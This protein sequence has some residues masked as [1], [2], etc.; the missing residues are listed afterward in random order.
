MLAKALLPKSNCIFHAAHTCCS[1]FV[2]TVEVFQPAW[3]HASLV[4][5]SNPV[6]LVLGSTVGLDGMLRVHGMH[7]HAAHL[8]PRP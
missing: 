8:A 2:L 5:Q 6:W 4:H 1:S 7:A 3:E